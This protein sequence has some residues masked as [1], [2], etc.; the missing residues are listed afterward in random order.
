M[1]APPVGG[2]LVTIQTGGQMD[3]WK[4]FWSQ[5]NNS[6]RCPPI[7]EAARRCATTI[8]LKAVGSRIFGRF[9]NFDKCRSKIL[10]DV[11]SGVAVDYVSTHVRATFGESGLNNGRI[12]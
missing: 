2:L 9:A 1:P 12:I 6:T 11:I 4:G 3:G 8:R 10:V 7:G 5:L